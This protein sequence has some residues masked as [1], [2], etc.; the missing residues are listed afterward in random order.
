MTK[1]TVKEVTVFRFARFLNE[2]LR[3]N[4]ISKEFTKYST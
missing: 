2:V 1:F 3:Q 4:Y